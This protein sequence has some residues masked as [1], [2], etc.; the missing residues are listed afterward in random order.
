MNIG[1]EISLYPLRAD[2]IPVIQA[3]ID[4]LNTDPRLKV[5]TNNMSTQVFGDYDLIF[6]LL[7]NECRATFA[8]TDK[9]VF[10]MKLLGPFDLA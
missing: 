8:A 9:S 2:Y 5:I 4:Q 3:F 10:V 1:V 6:D 7:H